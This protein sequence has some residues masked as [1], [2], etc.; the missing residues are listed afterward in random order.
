MLKNVICYLIGTK[1]YGILLSNRS[2]EVKITF[3]SDTDWSRDL[4]KRRS[5]AGLLIAINGGPIVSSCKL[6]QSTAQSTAEAEFNAL[7]YAIKKVKWIRLFL[8]ETKIID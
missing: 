6:Q 4:S 5:R 8:L 1:H 7:A 2:H 3:S